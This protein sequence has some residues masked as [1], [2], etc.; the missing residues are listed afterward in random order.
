MASGYEEAYEMVL[1]HD[2]S[3][4]LM[5][6]KHRAKQVYMFLVEEKDEEE[7]LIVEMA[8]RAS[9][10]VRWLL[11]ELIKIMEFFE[12]VRN[13][14]IKRMCGGKTLSL[15]KGM[16]DDD[17]DD[18]HD[19]VDDDDKRS[20]TDEDKES[21]TEKKESSRLTEEECQ[22]LVNLITTAAKLC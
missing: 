19:D 18:D 8:H 12:K 4:S 15:P 7:E 13:A 9:W 5:E 14:D 10:D 17:D 6:M 22:E 20:S 1:L 2:L 16:V 11:L 21:K 3:D